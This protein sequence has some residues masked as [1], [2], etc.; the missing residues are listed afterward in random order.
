MLYSD[1][2]FGQRFAD[3]LGTVASRDIN[4]FEVIIEGH[5]DG[6]TSLPRSSGIGECARKQYH[7]LIGAPVTDPQPGS[8]NWSSL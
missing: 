2:E 1:E 7:K 3:A 5:N 6:E 4:R 8:G